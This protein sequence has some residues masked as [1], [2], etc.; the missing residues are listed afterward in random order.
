MLHITA[1]TV[2]Q[3]PPVRQIRGR[4]LAFSKSKPRVRAQLAADM[5]AGRVELVALTL[6]Q[7]ARLCR[8]GR[9]SVIEARRPASV[10]LWK[11]WLEASPE[12]RRE[13][14]RSVGTE[15]IWNELTTAL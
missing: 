10:T 9:T 1:S 15:S 12:Q 2:L 4:D 7:A 3:T 8:V 14:I 6:R 11:T 5:V 13:F